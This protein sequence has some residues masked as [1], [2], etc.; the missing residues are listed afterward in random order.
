MNSAAMH[1]V[2]LI[3]HIAPSVEGP[4]HD[5]SIPLG[6]GLDTRLVVHNEPS[7][8]EDELQLS[9]GPQALPFDNVCHLMVLK[10]VI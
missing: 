5:I 10:Q 2:L 4:E 8:A 1:F 9:L 3:S 7:Q 6:H